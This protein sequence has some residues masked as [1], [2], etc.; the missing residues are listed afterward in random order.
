LKEVHYIIVWH[1]N[2][3]CPICRAAHCIYTSFIAPTTIIPAKSR[4]EIK[5]IEGTYKTI[6]TK[7]Q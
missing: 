6:Q 5:L 4:E 7:S 2:I 1:K 3:T